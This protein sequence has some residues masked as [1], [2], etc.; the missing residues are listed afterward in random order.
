MSTRKVNLYSTT[1]KID[2]SGYTSSATNAKELKAELAALGIDL[3][4]KSIMEFNNREEL[5]EDSVFAEGDLKLYILPA[6]V[7]SGK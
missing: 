1:G 4:N 7:K 2:K 3:K 5:T 6:E